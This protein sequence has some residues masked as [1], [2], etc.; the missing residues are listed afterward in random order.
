[1]TPQRFRTGITELFGIDHPILAGGLMWLS[2][3]RYVAAVVNAGGMGFITPRSFETLDEFREQL[4][5]CGRLTGGRPYGVNLTI[6]SRL[7][8]N[9]MLGSW[10]LAALEEG[11]RFFETAGMPPGRLVGDIHAAGGIVLHKSSK[12][13]H[14]LAAQREGVDALVIVGLEEGGHPGVNELPSTVMGAYAAT[15]LSLPWALG[16]GIGHGSQIAGA[17]AL[18][19]DA[20]MLGSRFM[21]C[22]ELWAHDDFK[23]HIVE[24]DEEC[25]TTAL[26]DLFGTWRVL[27]NDTVEEVKARERV[28]LTAFDDYKDLITGT[29]TRDE[30]YRRGN[31]RQ[32]MASLGPAAGFANRIE[33]MEHI[34]D[35][36]MQEA[37][38]AAERLADLVPAE[39]A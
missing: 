12:I 24:C 6:S 36:L 26:R 22:T 39:E 3:A 1:M 23:R 28:G 35:Q 25:S 14:A 9:A 15:R 27:K 32:G 21:T 33:P 8:S 10:L 11:V 19:A 18:G 5:L 4:R 31:W 38:S 7:E 17:L 37:V 29:L 13:R 34:I 16:G 2:D 30:C 20:V